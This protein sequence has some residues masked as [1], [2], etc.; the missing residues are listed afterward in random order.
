MAGFLTG[1]KTSFDGFFPG[2]FWIWMG[3]AVELQARLEERRSPL[4]E[5]Q[6][7]ALPD[8]LSPDWAQFRDGFNMF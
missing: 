5:E 6:E 1:K 4:K 2:G 8:L 7:E 3:Q